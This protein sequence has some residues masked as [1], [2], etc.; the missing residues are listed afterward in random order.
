MYVQISFGVDGGGRLRNN[1]KYPELQGS[2]NVNISRYEEVILNLAEALFEQGDMA[3]AITQLN[4]IT[5]NRGATAYAGTITKD[6]ILNERRKE[7]IFEGFRF[8]DLA[9]NGRDLPKISDLQIFTETIV[10]GDHRYA[11]PIPLVEMDAN[12]NMVQNKGYE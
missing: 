3:G 10:A 4:E 2:D 5:S 11:L 8:F 6:D 7:L 1:G 12:S 9:R